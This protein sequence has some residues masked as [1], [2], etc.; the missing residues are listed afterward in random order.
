MHNLS[1]AFIQPEKDEVIDGEKMYTFSII[2]PK[3]KVIFFSLNENETKTWIKIIH[4]T[5]GYIDISEIYTIKVTFKL[6]I[7]KLG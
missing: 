1:G 6:N 2:Y 3:N 5:I 7:T 4:S